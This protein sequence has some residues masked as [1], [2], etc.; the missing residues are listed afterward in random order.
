MPRNGPG[1]GGKR[2]GAP[3]AAYG[4]RTDL[5]QNR[6]P[7]QAAA[8]QPYGVR[9]AQ[10]AAQRAVPL[11]AAPPVRSAPPPAPASGVSPVTTGP[12]PGALG[13]LTRPTDRPD[14]PLTHGLPFGPGAGPEVIRAPAVL[15]EDDQLV[16]ELR[17]LYAAFPSPE[18][19]ALLSYAEGARNARGVAR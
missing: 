12:L 6:Q 4:N 14:E 3:G 8:G 9:G 13:S 10:E 2:Y 7:V 1:K 17:G 19:A 11:P 5:N 16:A 15:S 18:I